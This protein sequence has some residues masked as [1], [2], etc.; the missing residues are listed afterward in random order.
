MWTPTHPP[1]P[2]H[3]ELPKIDMKTEIQF[4]ILPKNYTVEL[5][6]M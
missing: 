2:P 3:T 6:F 1:T 4:K 5:V